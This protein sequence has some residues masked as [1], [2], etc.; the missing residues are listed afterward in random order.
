MN[1]LANIDTRPPVAR[2]PRPGSAGILAGV[3]LFIVALLLL[4]PR[5]EAQ[6]QITLVVNVAALPVSATNTTNSITIANTTLNF[7]NTPLASTDVQIGATTAL[8]ASN[9]FTALTTN[10]TISATLST[11]KLF[12][13]N[14]AFSLTAPWGGA[15][16]NLIVGPWGS[17]Y[18]ETNSNNMAASVT[19]SGYTVVTPYTFFKCVAPTNFITLP[20]L[21]ALNL[22]YKPGAE[23][24][25]RKTDGLTNGVQ[26]YAGTGTSLVPAAT[27]IGT[28]LSAEAP[29]TNNTGN[30][31]VWDGTTN[32]VRKL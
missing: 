17:S 14:S 6:Q 1:P 7:T 5:A 27:A 12:F 8:T 20:S 22:L 30:V 26:V 10:A 29:I 15:L 18:L 2:R 3:F 28:F 9:L 24:N 16:T 19:N 31:Y 13:G 32:L 23:F 25:L 21:T 11:N 4:A